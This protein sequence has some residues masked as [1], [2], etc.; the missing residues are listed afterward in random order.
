M[1][2]QGVK[3]SHGDHG[4]LPGVLAND[5]TR[6]RRAPLPCLAGVSRWTP[7]DSLGCQRSLCKMGL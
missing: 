5:H 6:R 3:F 1:P 7:P 2:E 4:I